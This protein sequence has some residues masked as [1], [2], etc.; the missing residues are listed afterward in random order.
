MPTFP[1][2]VL[3]WSGVSIRE[4][5]LNIIYQITP[6]DTPFFNLIG[7]SDATNVMHQWPTRALTTRADNANPEGDSLSTNKDRALVPARVTNITQIL[8]KRPT[9]TRTQ[10]SVDT[11]GIT[12]LMADQIQQ[13]S[14]EFKTDVEHALLRG[15]LISGNTD[16]TAPR[17][18]GGYHNVLSTNYQYYNSLFSL[19]EE[20]FND[21]LET[22]WTAGGRAQ[23]VLVN[24]RLK[25]T[26]SAFTDS[27]TKFFMA[28]DKRVTN[29]IGVY[30]SDFHV[31]NIH[32][33][34]DV[35]NVVGTYDVYAFDRSFFAKAWLDQPIIERLPKTI[36][37]EEAY[38]V[39]ELT[40]EYGN[41]AAAGQI[42]DLQLPGVS[43]KP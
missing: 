26:I 24:G 9:V 22:I 43:T 33:S 18:M 34:R 17:R 40:L 20:M 1:T 39:A 29:T 11:I 38:I 3:Q 10:N 31:T 14:V 42:T 25:R 28:E 2:T 15:S 23:D 6:E 32:L 7:D 21:L 16:G 8:D 30:E 13:R 5:V 41:E 12:D 37:G 35:R 27:A 19:H 4:D 36:D